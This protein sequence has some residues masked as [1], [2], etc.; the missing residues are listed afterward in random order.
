MKVYQTHGDKRDIIIMNVFKNLAKGLN[1]W[2]WPVSSSSPWWA[3]NGHQSHYSFIWFSWRISGKGLIWCK[4]AKIYSTFLPL[5]LC[6]HFPP[7]SVRFAVLM[8]RSIF[9]ER[10]LNAKWESRSLKTIASQ[11]N[12]ISFKY[13]MAK[14]NLLHFYIMLCWL[15]K[16]A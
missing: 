16:M 11:D 3:K 14:W 1:W 4:R 5:F 8:P 7:R 6:F 15:T 2:F 12:S 9:Q 13:I 10:S